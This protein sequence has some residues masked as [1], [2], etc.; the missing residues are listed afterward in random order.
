MQW[1]E[2]CIKTTSRRPLSWSEAADDARLRQLYYGRSGPSSTSFWKTSNYRTIMNAPPPRSENPDDSG[3]S[4]NQEKTEAMV[5]RKKGKKCWQNRQ[6]A[7]RVPPLPAREVA[8]ELLNPRWPRRQQ[9][10][11][12]VWPVTAR[13][14]R[15]RMKGDFGSNEGLFRRRRFF[16]HGEKLKGKLDC[17]ERHFDFTWSAHR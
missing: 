7:G 11:C 16:P 14:V 15:V 1:I 6:Q 2:V 9:A 8:G 17:Q 4:H 12:N 3:T 5:K 13:P 10:S